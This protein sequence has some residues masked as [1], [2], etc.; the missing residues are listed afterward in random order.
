M[1]SQGLGNC[2]KETS[3]FLHRLLDGDANLQELDMIKDMKTILRDGIDP[4][5]MFPEFAGNE[6]RQK[7]VYTLELRQYISP[8]QVS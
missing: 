5:T 7:I 6:R 8:V 1:L 4:I 3:R 2:L